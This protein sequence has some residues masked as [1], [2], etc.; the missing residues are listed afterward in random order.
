MGAVVY[1]AD[2]KWYDERTG[3]L[4]DGKVGLLP[5]D[6]HLYGARGM[7]TAIAQFYKLVCPGLILT[8]HI[9]RGLNRDLCC[10]G[11]LESASNK[12]I[13]TRKPATDYVWAGGA[14]GSPV[15]KAAPSGKVFGVIIS[16]RHEKHA[17]EFGEILGWIDH[18]SWIDEDSALSEAPIDWI[19]RYERKLWT[20]G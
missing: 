18:W 20:R 14:Q 4:Q 3:S 10:D 12:L 17:D 16:P 9:F 15:A 2:V 6:L 5:K 8:R 19:D 11:D 7:G 1:T 13:Y